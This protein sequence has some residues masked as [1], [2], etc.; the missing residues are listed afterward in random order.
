MIPKVGT[1]VMWPQTRDSAISYCTM[2]LD[3]TL[4]KSDAYRTGIS[5]YS[6]CDCGY[7]SE[8]VEHFILQ[9]PKYDSGQL[10]DTVESLWHDVK[11]GFAFDNCT[12]LLHLRAMTLLE[13]KKIYLSSLHCLTFNQHQQ[14]V[15]IYQRVL[16]LST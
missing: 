10:I 8:I 16:Q 9:C 12:L 15:I 14:T 1:K 5:T 2:L 6:V 13:E 4:L 11:V 3:D 7:D